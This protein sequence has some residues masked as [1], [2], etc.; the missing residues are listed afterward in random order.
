M[1]DYR[2]AA[3][4]DCSL[5]ADFQDTRAHAHPCNCVTSQMTL[6]ARGTRMTL[7][8]PACVSRLAKLMIGISLPTFDLGFKT[9]VR[10][11]LVGREP[12]KR[13]VV[14]VLSRGGFFP[15]E[16]RQHEGL[17]QLHRELEVAYCKL[18]T[19]A[20]DSIIETNEFRYHEAYART[21]NQLD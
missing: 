21:L 13:I 17:V 16:R 1:R 18:V 19:I 6:D 10:A 5:N 20:T 15:K 12:V 2:D 14:L 9:W 3:A 11:Y 8:G 7:T 4:R